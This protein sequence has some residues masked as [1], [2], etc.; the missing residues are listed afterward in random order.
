MEIRIFKG[1]SKAE[2]CLVAL[3]GC[4]DALK[5]NEIYP[6]AGNLI[7]VGANRLKNMERRNID[8][9]LQIITG[10]SPNRLCNISVSNTNLESTIAL[11]S[12]NTK[13]RVITECDW[14]GI[15]YIQAKDHHTAVA[16]NTNSTATIDLKL[17]GTNK[18]YHLAFTV[19]KKI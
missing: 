6:T 18:S 7:E 11:S 4:Q 15:K 10:E 5:R 2:G 14:I 12:I 17:I 3:S 16:L 1:F 13:D 19:V 8:N 9:D